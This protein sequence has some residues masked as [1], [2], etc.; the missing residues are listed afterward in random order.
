MT[1]YRS[2][3]F[4]QVCF[5][6]VVIFAATFVAA[7]ERDA[8]VVQ[9]SNRQVTIAFHLVDFK[10]DTFQ[11]NGK[12]SNRP[13]FERA[14][15]LSNAG[16]PE[17]P[18]RVF[19]VGIPAGAQAEVSAVSGT[20]EELSEI[21]IPSVPDKE[22][23]DD[24]ARWRYQPDSQIYA[25]DAF[26]P[27]ELV[28][29]D[30][31]A[32]F[33][34]Q[35]I[36]RVQVMPVQYNPAQK[37]L[38]VYHDL[39]IVVRFVNGKQSV[40][41]AAIA[42]ASQVEEE[43]YR[44]LLIN[45]EQAKAFRASRPQPLLR[46]AHPQI[47][48][49]LY[50]FSLRQEGIYKLDGKTLGSAGVDLTN[51]KP[52]TIH[53]Y[54]N[55]GREL[56]RRLNAP[57]PQGLIENAIYVSDGGDGRF[58][59]DD[60]ILFYG[61]GVEGFAVDSTTGAASRYMNHFGHDNFYWLSFGGN[62]GKRMAERATQPVSGLTP[63]ASF[64]EYL[65]VEEELQPLF[66]SDQLWF[67][68]LF[69][70]EGTSQSRRYRVKLNDPVNESVAHLKF[71]FYAPP[72]GTRRQLTVSFEKQE[73]GIF[74]SFGDDEVEFRETNKVGGLVNGDNEILLSYQGSGEA[75]Q[76]YIDYFELR[77]ER[78]LKLNSDM[79]IFNGR[80]GAGPFAY[81]LNNVEANS[82]WLFE[83][84][85]F[86]E[87]ARLSSQNWQTNDG[88]MTFADVGASGKTPRRYIAATPTAFKNVDPKTI[89]RAEISN[90]R[91]PTQ[92]AD[93][94]V[95]THEDFLSLNPITGK[96]EGPL[97][98]FAS[99]R[100]NANVS[101]TL[102]VEVVK[103]HEVFD[104]FSCG[105]YDPVAIRDFLRYA[106]ESWPR[107][108]VFVMLVG[109]GDYDP[110]NI[111][112]KTAPNW[113]PTYHTAEFD[114]GN[115]VPNR[116]TDSW[117]TYVAGD[118]EAMDMA[119]GRIPGRSLA[120]VE[121]YID[122]VIRYETTPVFGAWRNTVV[123]VA[124]D[125][126]AQGGVPSFDETFHIN[127]TETLVSLTPAFFDLKKI[128][129]TEF[130][131][132]QSASISGIRKPAATDAFLRLVNNGAVLV[133][134]AGHGNPDVWSHERVLNLSTDF[135]RIQN[136]DRQALWIAATCT[137]G[138]YDMPDRQSFAEQL[139]LAPRRGAIAALATSRDVYAIDNAR[140]NQ[141]LY[142]FL[143][144]DGKQISSRIGAAMILARLQTFNTQNDEKFHV[145]GDPS[146]RLATPRYNATITSIKPDT[147]KA[148]TVMTVQGKIQ[149]DGVD[150]PGFDGAARI[151]ALDA[152]REVR[153][154]SPGQFSIDYA[155]P[156]NSLFRGEVP[157]KNGVFSAQFFVPKDI[158]YGGQTGRFN[159]YFWNNTADGSGYRERLP[160]GGSATNLVDKVGPNID[161]S[162]VAAENFQPGGVIGANPV[163]RAVISDSVS[164]I[165][166]TGEIG[167][168][169]TLTIDGR[170]DDKIDLTD[171]FD[172]D[173]GS[174]TRGAVIYP[175]GNLS[176]GRHAVEIKAWDNLNNSNVRE[177]D[178]TVQSQD[179][180]VL[181]QVMNYPNPFR[182]RTTFTFELNLA[183]EA[184]IKIF[185][186]SG[187][188]I[189]TLEMFGAQPGFNM[190]EWDG[191]DEDG[192]ELANGVYLYKI[193]ATQKQNDAM[194]RAEEIGKLVVQR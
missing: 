83:V 141:K 48:G 143:F 171:L 8:Q 34:Q 14:I 159:L 132:V 181:S 36:A 40:S 45:Y 81:T 18:T 104:E 189:R 137:F 12:L 50:K 58:D 157:V 101:D 103:I 125:E 56:P 52:N 16:A 85:N 166:I 146:L 88:Q 153:Y 79:L 92:G 170:N 73:L 145:L 94:V 13:Y 108:P 59:N 89:V 78:Q 102:K 156:G 93:M 11:I 130:A 168:K 38:R 178:F 193:I 115:Y 180:L 32:Q 161:I 96:D 33:R 98:R 105:L 90:L 74:E 150:W 107:R 41:T 28:R 57:R 46:K 4:S 99:L 15:F 163:L 42:P 67:G 29:V 136:G 113:I 97:A 127:D 151:E 27:S 186:L 172:Y 164:G 188:L 129:L 109:D 80:A 64:T 187:R 47:E 23:A 72:S 123:M 144:E 70:N 120:D 31:P 139:I 194:W 20:I 154:Q 87:V 10:L 176:E 160:V 19:V 140:L 110:K 51:V 118:D 167:H 192:D 43:F 66:E 84:S 30:P 25:R 119:I 71:A 69:T 62:N 162:F 39:Q 182:R 121:A 133:N 114:Y 44:G 24:L 106:Y 155:M 165:N 142:G 126:Y 9:T 3:K 60:Y 22:P 35:T 190:M 65:F 17:L 169:I 112:N 183:A 2:I 54:N 49:P 185:T 75:A 111:L 53:L 82:L 179:R 122:K 124:D 191:Q 148:L 128:Y 131:A 158:T 173:A 134:Y 21:H 95:I 63:A 86:N 55:G 116:V 149:R 76:L 6:S 26:Y 138:K 177:V 100:Q 152:Q 174:Y 135:E 175:L 68:W 37:R 7:S 77:Y 147:L 184:R 61:R 1:F 117:Y 91:S 5:F